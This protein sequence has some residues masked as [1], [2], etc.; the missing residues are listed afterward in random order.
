MEINQGPIHDLN[1]N[2]NIVLA[3]LLR[4]Y[5]PSLPISP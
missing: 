2:K 1:L 3:R 4:L 5:L